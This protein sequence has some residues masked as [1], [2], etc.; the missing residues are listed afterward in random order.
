[1]Q[2]VQFASSALVGSTMYVFG[3]VAG[4]SGSLALSSQQFFC[5]SLTSFIVTALPNTAAHD[6]FPFQRVDQPRLDESRDRHLPLQRTG[7]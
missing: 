3:G 5:I 7:R 6:F 2:G 1:M 4:A